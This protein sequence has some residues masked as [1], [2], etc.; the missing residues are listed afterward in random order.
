MPQKS[1]NS[2]VEDAQTCRNP[3]CLLVWGRGTHIG[4]VALSASDACV[5]GE[6]CLFRSPLHRCQLSHGRMRMEESVAS[7]YNQSISHKDR[8]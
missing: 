1:T 5:R 4:Q 3:C 7:T 2:P 8:K 6:K